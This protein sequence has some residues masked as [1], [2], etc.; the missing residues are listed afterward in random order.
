MK[1]VIMKL[2]RIVGFLL[3]AALIYFSVGAYFSN[4]AAAQTDTGRIMIFVAGALGF[5]MVVSN[6]F[7]AKTPEAKPTTVTNA[8]PQAE[9]KCPACNKPIEK[10]FHHC[11]H[12][13]VNLH[14]VCPNCKKEVSVEFKVCPYCATQLKE[15]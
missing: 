7:P 3:G 13:G 6:L 8:S 5:L 9:H 2:G 15:E 11:P 14:P 4:E 10:S 12:C 1:G